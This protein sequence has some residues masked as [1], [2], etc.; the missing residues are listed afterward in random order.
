MSKTDFTRRAMLTGG[1][2][3]SALAVAGCSS[4]RFQTF[5]SVPALAPD[6]PE[7][8]RVPRVNMEIIPHAYH[9][10]RVLYGSKEE[11]GTIIVDTDERFLYLVE[12]GGTAIRYGIGVGRRG[13]EWKGTAKIR[14]KAK[15]PRWVPPAEMVARDPVAARY[16]NGWDGGPTNP[17][18]ARALYLYQGKRDTLYRIHGTNQPRSIGKA[19]SSGCV[20]MLNHDVVDLYERVPNGTKVVVL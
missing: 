20:R 5:G 2:T 12:D 17:L 7:R 3:L 9:R 15:W 10:R 8:F 1:L 14:R 11:P 16:K 4:T 18:G 6:E 13:F 19:M